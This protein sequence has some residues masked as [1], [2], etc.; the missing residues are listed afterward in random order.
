MPHT[1]WLRSW[2]EQYC[3]DAQP[4]LTCCTRAVV[5][6]TICLAAFV[7]LGCTEQP[8]VADSPDATRS[9]SFLSVPDLIPDLGDI[10]VP[11]YP[12][13]PDFHHDDGEECDT[14]LIINPCKPGSVCLP[15]N[16]GD[17]M[18]MCTKVQG[19]CDAESGP[20]CGCNGR[21]Y[22]N[23]CAAMR[24][25]VLATPGIC[26]GGPCAGCGN[27][28]CELECSQGQVCSDANNGACV[29]QPECCEDDGNGLPACGCDGRLYATACDAIREGVSPGREFDDCDSGTCTEDSECLPD[30]YCRKQPGVQG[31]CVKRPTTC[32]EACGDPVCVTDGIWYAS[33]CHALRDGKTI[34]DDPAV[35]L[36]PTFCTDCT[37]GE[38]W[39]PEEDGACCDPAS[40]SSAGACVQRPSVLTCSTQPTGE[41]CGCDGR[42]YANRCYAAAAGV[43][44]DFDGPCPPPPACPGDCYPDQVDTACGSQVRC[45]ERPETCSEEVLPVCGCNG[46]T[47]QNEC[48]ALQAGTGVWMNG[49]CPCGRSTTCNF[50]D[51]VC[52][53]CGRE[54]CID[55]PDNCTDDIL[56]VCGCDGRTYPNECVAL[57]HGVEKDYE[58][59]CFCD[60]ATQS[61]CDYPDYVCNVCDAGSCVKV[62]D[63]CDGYEPVCGCDGKTYDN[64]CEA[65]R[66]GVGNWTEGCCPWDD[67]P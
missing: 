42:T 6:V 66:A 49:P 8:P 15:A 31:Y 56:P 64:R 10:Y 58:G 28:L 52:S 18:G 37:A 61:K 46:V 50:P 57:Q 44:V 32:G 4:S 60:I 13:P 16:C 34:A 22:V 23:Q 35:C 59:P 65:T 14:R 45:V 40:P 27:P 54:T 29:Q 20:V 17:R 30:E 55:R 24:A 51:Q 21:T 2:R 36:P 67:S 7:A 39:Q 5:L 48:L 53:R 1:K 9:S 33:A 41:V 62:E 3:R 26:P 12:D 38:Y 19:N 25:G 47:Y 63:G 43:T 11:D